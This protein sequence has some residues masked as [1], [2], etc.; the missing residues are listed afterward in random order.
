MDMNIQKFRALLTVVK[1]G[2]FTRAAEL[3]HYSQSAISRMINDLEKDWDITLLERSRTGVKLTSEGMKLLPFANNVCEQHRL[4]QEEI[5]ALNGLQT[6]LIRIGTFS[7]VATHWLPNIITAFQKDYPNIHFEFLLGDYREID[8]WI[9]AGR[10][11]CGFTRLPVGSEFATQF[12]QQD[13]Y[14]AVLPEGHDLATYATIPMQ[15]LCTYPFILLEK[16]SNNEISQIFQ[17][18]KLAPQVKFTLWDDYAIMAMVEKNLGISVLP[19]LILKQKPDRIITRPI[20]SSPGRNIGF[21]WRENNCSRAVSCFM[22]Y[23]HYRNA[24]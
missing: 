9:A 18:H 3:L 1:C 16:D 11:D 23:L 15:A 2:S 22:Q 10:V 21:A 7:S 5:N 17:Q 19:G 4:L 13:E 12:M 20:V 24:T 14:L 6:G 8:N